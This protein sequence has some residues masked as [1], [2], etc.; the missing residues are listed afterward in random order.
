MKNHL[1][2]TLIELLVV[3]LIIGILAA[4]ALPQYKL[5]V[6]KS[7]ISAYF[8]L[9]KSIVNAQEAYYLANAQYASSLKDLDITM[10][11]ECVADTS[12]S[13]TGIHWSCGKDMYITN[14]H[15]D[16]ESYNPPGG[17]LLLTYCPGKNSKY[18]DCVGRR[19]MLFRF[20]YQHLPQSSMGYGEPSSI[21]CVVLNGSSFGDRIC[22]SFRNMSSPA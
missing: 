13:G 17:L 2:F 20:M 19:D 6:A 9:A 1:G 8:P 10:P 12:V 5:A 14:F 4:I 16:G 7:K 3:V 22:K 15:V 11:A 18:W 21:V